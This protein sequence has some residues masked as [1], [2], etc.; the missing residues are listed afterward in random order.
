MERAVQHAAAS[1]NLPKLSKLSKLNFSYRSPSH[2][3]QP[4]FFPPPIIP[5]WQF[6]V[7]NSHTVDFYP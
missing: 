3:H 6:W 5:F 1:C 2:N 7:M 4:I